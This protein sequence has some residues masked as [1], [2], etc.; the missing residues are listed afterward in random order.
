MLTILLPCLGALA[1]GPD[2][3]DGGGAGGVYVLTSS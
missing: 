1:R 2:I 3:R